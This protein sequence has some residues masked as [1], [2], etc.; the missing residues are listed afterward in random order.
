MI[1]FEGDKRI[2]RP[3]AE[4]AAK[5]SD[6]GFLANSVPD[7]E[8]SE[9]TPDRATGK[10]KPKLSFLTGSLTLHAEVTTRVPGKSV[11]YRIETKTMGASSTVET[12]LV[13]GEAEGGTLV[14]WTGDI[15]AVTGLLKM[16]PK[17]LLEGTAKKVIEDVWAAVESKI[18]SGS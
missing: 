12:T 14:H 2:G 5:L 8:V 11:A 6:A 17:G 4:V 15:V 7:A 9:N 18:T 13:F 16:V 3:V 10:I 1:H